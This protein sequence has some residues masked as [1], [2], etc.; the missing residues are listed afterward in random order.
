MSSISNNSLNESF[1]AAPVKPCSEMT[2]SDLSAQLSVKAPLLV[3]RLNDL[4]LDPSSSLESLIDT[5]KVTIINES[6]DGVKET[7]LGRLESLLDPTSRS[8]KSSYEDLAKIF[9]KTTLRDLKIFE[10]LVS[11]TRDSSIAGS[12]SSCSKITDSENSS[13]SLVYPEFP[14]SL[15]SRA[16]LISK[17]EQ[18][19]EAFLSRNLPDLTLENYRAQFIN[20]ENRRDIFVLLS[21]EIKEILGRYPAA[22]TVAFQA[23]HQIYGSLRHFDENTDDSG[24]LID[25]LKFVEKHLYLQSAPKEEV[26]SFLQTLFTHETAISNR[27]FQLLIKEN[28]AGKVS[29]PEVFSKL[30]RVF[31]HLVLEA[32]NLDS[33]NQAPKNGRK[34]SADPSEKELSQFRQKTE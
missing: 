19:I 34:R 20:P 22:I 7:V 26:V 17:T 23:L 25:V 13:S 24:T 21:P 5:F 9:P 18:Q 30:A 29:E 2:F 32:K 4:D 3:W 33:P 12:P 6:P 31:Y 8:E 16:A 27:E 14:N 15:L 10:R 28:F 11:L 1:G